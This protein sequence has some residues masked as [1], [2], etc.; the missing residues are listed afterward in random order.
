ITR[1]GTHALSV[2]RLVELQ[3]ALLDLINHRGDELA[4]AGGDDED[5]RAIASEIIALIDSGWMGLFWTG[6][7]RSWRLSRY[8]TPLTVASTVP[9]LRCRTAPINFASAGGG[10]APSCTISTVAILAFSRIS[11]STKP[12]SH[13]S[14]CGAFSM[15]ICPVRAAAF[16]KAAARSGGCCLGRIHPDGCAPQQSR[17][18][19]PT[20][21]YL[22]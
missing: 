5:A 6:V 19:G 16:A 13:L 20:W 15:R 8:L 3:G 2:R 1:W 7:H 12:S 10:L 11:F 9:P 22:Q 18:Y 21:G 14:F 17:V 4:S